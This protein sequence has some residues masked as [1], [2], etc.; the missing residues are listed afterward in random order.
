MKTNE[1]KIMDL[2]RNCVVIDESGHLDVKEDFF[3]R[4]QCLTQ[5]QE[6]REG[7]RAQALDEVEAA[8]K[9][10]DNQ[11][12]FVNNRATQA[13][14]KLPLLTA[15]PIPSPGAEATQMN[16]VYL[17]GVP[18]TDTTITKSFVMLPRTPEDRL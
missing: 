7:E 3:A 6:G 18:K 5:A 2:L 4:L 10:Y 1:E 13:L 16:T 15:R 9:Y 14:E 12:S 11:D 8:L 17:E